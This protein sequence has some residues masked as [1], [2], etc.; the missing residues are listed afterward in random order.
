MPADTEAAARLRA[1]ELMQVVQSAARET[2]VRDLV[3]LEAHARR[4]GWRE[5]E[6]VAAAG[7]TMSVLLR[8]DADQAAAA[9]DAL[10]ARARSASRQPHRRAWASSAT[11]SRTAVSRAAL[12]TTCISS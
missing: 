4:C 3:A 11:R 12:W 6:L 8:S 2:A 7:L 9:T 1:Y 5:A 10:V